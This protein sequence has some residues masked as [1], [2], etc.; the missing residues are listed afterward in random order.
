MLKM[1]STQLAGLFKRIQEKNE[2][3]LEDGARLLA[4]A[5][6]GDGTIY[7]HGIHEMEAV[8]A[9][10]TEGAEPFSQIK[11]W[12]D[13]VEVTPADRVV[14]F[15]RFSNDAE[16]V[17]LSKKLVEL[18]IPFV[19]VSTAT[20]DQEALTSMADVHIDLLLSK[21]LI[22]N[23]FGNRVGYPASMAALFVYYGLKFTIDEILLTTLK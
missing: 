3:S 14:L 17:N 21:G 22:P 15:S 9:E 18:G 23:E 10:A 1:F 11:R 12:Q 16:A 20:G 6:I 5:A 2:F 4:Q 19:A 8:V 13:S 7:L